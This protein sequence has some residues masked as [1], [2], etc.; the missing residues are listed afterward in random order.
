ME[1]TYDVIFN[2]DLNCNVKGFRK[3][4][5]YCKDYISCNNG[6]AN[7]YFK[8]YRGGTVAV[9]CNETGEDMY[10]EEVR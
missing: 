6:T 9:I 1:K 3:S 2:D 10:D 5:Q 4:L 7:S 8:D